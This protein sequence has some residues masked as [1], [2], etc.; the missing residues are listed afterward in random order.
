MRPEFLAY[1]SPDQIMGVTSGLAAIVGLALTFWNKVV[2]FFGKLANKI[3][4]ASAPQEA[5]KKAVGQD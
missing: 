3:H 2:G 4:P 1:V 5:T